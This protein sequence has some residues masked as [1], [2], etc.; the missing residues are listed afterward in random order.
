MSRKAK[1][2]SS[3]LIYYRILTLETQEVSDHTFLTVLRHHGPIVTWKRGECPSSVLCRTPK[4]VKVKPLI[5]GLRPASFSGTSLRFCICLPFFII[6]KTSSDPN[7]R[8]L[9]IPSA[10][11]WNEG[12]LKTIVMPNIHPSTHHGFDR[13]MN[14]WVLRLFVRLPIANE[15]MFCSVALPVASTSAAS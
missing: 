3:P 5:S 14:Q 1:L 10:L 2:A 15:T 12:Q 4:S 8:P 13:K 9:K 11:V 6:G 7:D